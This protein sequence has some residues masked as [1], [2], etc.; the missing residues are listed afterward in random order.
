[1][2]F[3]SNVADMSH[4][5][6]LMPF[7]LSSPNINRNTFVERMHTDFGIKCAIQYYPLSAL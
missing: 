6:H 2:T 4:C 7:K 5:N 3:Q 1:M